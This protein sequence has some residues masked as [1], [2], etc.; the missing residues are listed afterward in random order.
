M[1]EN[2]RKNF[3]INNKKIY[4]LITFYNKNQAVNV[5]LLKT[6]ATVKLVYT[7]CQNS[8]IML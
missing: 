8:I 3:H 1:S 2:V 4:F 6:K 7:K 5:V